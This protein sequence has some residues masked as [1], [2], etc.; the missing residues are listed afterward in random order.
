MFENG[1]AQFAPRDP[2][3]KEAERHTGRTRPPPLPLCI[4]SLH[5]RC[6]C[7]GGVSLVCRCVCG[8]I[9]KNPDFLVW[10][11]HPE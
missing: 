10:E 7:A 5:K 4:D 9:I 1:G 3:R 11:S 6:V 8:N 2:Q